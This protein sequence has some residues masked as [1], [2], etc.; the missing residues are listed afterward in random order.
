MFHIGVLA[1]ISGFLAWSEMRQDIRG[2][3]FPVSLERTVIWSLDRPARK[4]MRQVMGKVSDNPM[5]LLIDPANVSGGLLAT[6]ALLYC[7]KK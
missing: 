1:T 4:H 3:L 5:F 6:D 2:R 7:V